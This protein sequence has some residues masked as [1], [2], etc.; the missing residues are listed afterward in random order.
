MVIKDLLDKI[1]NRMFEKAKHEFFSCIQ[2]GNSN[3]ELFKL[4]TEKKMIKTMWCNTSDCEDN[5]KKMVKETLIKVNEQKKAKL[6]LKCE[7]EGKEYEAPEDDI[8]EI[9]A[10]TMCM[11]LQQDPIP[12]DQKCFSCDRQARKWVLWGKT[13]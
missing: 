4:L 11:P 13:Y 5:V 2:I 8:T 7:K 12:Q 3:E 6:K 9:T 1:Q 10:K